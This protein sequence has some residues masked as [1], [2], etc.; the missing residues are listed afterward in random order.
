MNDRDTRVELDP[1]PLALSRPAECHF[2][3]VKEEFLIHPTDRFE[4]PAV[5]E[6]AGP[7]DPV[8]R[9][10][11]DPPIGLV[12]P[13][14]PWYQL[15]PEGPKQARKRTDGRLTRPIGVPQLEADDSGLAFGSPTVVPD[16]IQNSLDQAGVRDDVRIEDQEPGGASL[17]PAGVDS[18]RE[19]VVLGL[20]EQA[21]AR[22][23]I[24]QG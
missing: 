17:P 13:P 19:A 1:P 14:N 20:R 22:S 21:Y 16:P 23:R 9:A 2:F 12:F 18:A 10:G 8:D 5:E 15:L 11:T 7:G 6:H 3:I 24:E 4:H